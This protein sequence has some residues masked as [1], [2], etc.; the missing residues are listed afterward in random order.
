MYE[1]GQ[2]AFF[3]AMKLLT[4]ERPTAARRLDVTLQ[5]RESTGPAAA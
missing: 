4:G 3:M 2:Q 5:L 1:L